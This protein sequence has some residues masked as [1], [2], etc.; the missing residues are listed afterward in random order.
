MCY[1]F[2]YRGGGI[3][4]RLYTDVKHEKN[5]CNLCSNY[6]DLRSEHLHSHQR[7]LKGKCRLDFGKTGQKKV[8]NDKNEKKC[9]DFNKKGNSSYKNCKF[10]HEYSI[11]G[12]KLIN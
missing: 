8:K 6:K 9:L 3:N 11:C 4:K 7:P 5:K 2:G 1:I 10:G 12:M